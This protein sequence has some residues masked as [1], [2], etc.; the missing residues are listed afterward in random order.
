MAFLQESIFPSGI[1]QDSELRSVPQGDFL[2][3]LNIRINSTAGNQEGI[4]SNIKGNVLVAFTLP[5]GNNTRIGTLSDKQTGDVY[6]FIYNSNGNHGIFRFRQPNLIETVFISPLLNF[7]PDY[8]INHAN[9]V[10]E[11]LLYWTDGFNPPRK[12]NVEKALEGKQR[13]YNIYLGDNSGT[14]E[15]YE[16]KIKDPNGNVI[17]SWTILVPVPAVGT[18]DAFYAA[19]YIV[20]N[21]PAGVPATLIQESAHIFLTMSNIGEYT[22]EA[23]CIIPALSDQVIA[24]ADNFYPKP[25]VED[26]IDRLKYPFHCEPVVTY[27]ADQSIKVNL[28]KEKVFQFRMGYVYDDDEYSSLSPISSIPDYGTPCAQSISQ[29]ALNYIEIDFTEARLNNVSSRAIIKYV[30]IYFREHNDGKWKLVQTITPEEFGIGTQLF[31]FYNDGLY[32]VISDE[33]ADTLFSTLPIVAGATE[34]IGK[35]LTDSNIVEGYDPVNVDA[36]LEVKYNA[37]AFTGVTISGGVFIVSLGDLLSGTGKQPM[38]YLSGVPAEANAVFGG[39][40]QTFAQPNEPIIN[41]STNHSQR[42]PIYGFPFYLAGTDLFGVTKQDIIP[43]LSAFQNTT[44]GLINPIGLTQR[45]TAWQ[46]MR[47]VGYRQSWQITNVPPGRYLLRVGSHLTTAAELVDGTRKYQR[48]ST[49]IR[50]AAQSQTTFIDGVVGTGLNEAILEVLANGTVNIYSPGSFLLI[51]TSTN[52]VLPDTHIADISHQEFATNVSPNFVPG[53]LGMMGYLTDGEGTITPTSFSEGLNLE[54]VTRTKVNIEFIIRQIDLSESTHNTSV[55]TDHNGFFWWAAGVRTDLHP[56]LKQVTLQ[57]YVNAAT[58]VVSTV[59]LHDINNFV[60]T[61][62]QVTFLSS[63]LSIATVKL[64]LSYY[65]SAAFTANGRTFIEGVITDIGGNPLSGVNVAIVWHGSIRTDLNGRYQISF[66]HAYVNVHTAYIVPSS[67]GLCAF[68]IISPIIGYIITVPFFIGSANYNDT[69]LFT[70]NDFIAGLLFAIRTNALKRGGDYEIGY[71]YYDRGNRSNTVSLNEKLKLHIYFYTEPDASNNVFPAGQ[72]DVT[73]KTRHLPPVFFIDA[74]GVKHYPTHYQLLRTK[75][76]Q[77][78]WYLQWLANEVRYTDKPVPAPASN[79]MTYASGTY[80]SIKLTNFQ[81]YYD[82]NAASQIAYNYTKGDRIR[83]IADS[84]DVMHTQYFDFEILNWDSVAQEI[85]IL[86]DFSLP[87]QFAGCFFEI[88]SPRPDI[89]NKLYFECSECYEVKLDGN[90]NPYHEAPTQNQN[91]ADPYNTPAILTLKTGDAWYRNRSIPYTTSAPQQR[92]EFVDD[93]SI[94]DFYKSDDSSIGRINILELN[95]GQIRRGKTLRW[96]GD[97]IANLKINNLSWNLSGDTQ[98]ILK[99]EGTVN[100]LQVAGRILLAMQGGQVTSVYIYESQFLDATG[101]VNVIKADA[102]IGSMNPLQLLSGTNHPESVQE[103]QGRVYYYDAAKGQVVR[104]SND[105]QT[106][107]S[108][109]GM[110]SYFKNK[111]KT[112]TGRAYG[113]IVPKNLEYGITFYDTL[114]SKSKD[115]VVF[116]D[117]ERSRRWTSRYSFVPEGYAFSDMELI[118]FRDGALWVGER[119]NLRNNFF[120]VQYS[121]RLTLV[122]NENNSKTRTFIALVVDGSDVWHA[123]NDNDIT[124]P[125]SVKYPQGMKS[126]LLKNLFRRNATDWY[127]PFKKDL[128]SPNKTPQE[129]I[130]NG[131]DLMGHVIKISLQNDSTEEVTLKSVGVRYL[132]DEFTKK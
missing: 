77:L 59:P 119:N 9:I 12:I 95:Y 4:V 118:M 79:T 107:I 48:T 83:F 109:Y 57:Q 66:Y 75:N 112:F 35:K 82:I 41:P 98:D 65:N 94:S 129:A 90:G 34:F 30:T 103:Y 72:P 73:V 132:V 56:G 46:Y 51:Y 29:N 130:S 40:T 123:P 28:V 84:N 31:R 125:P 42:A 121:S 18:A 10:D 68:Q 92:T 71:V 33:L 111:A 38:W 23:A 58:T 80:L 2:D 108:D 62:Y 67:T 69:T 63:M 117:Q 7:S 44:T 50:T 49:T 61:F 91:P 15:T 89:E 131:R 102:F 127:T 14:G 87:E 86:K 64:G 55:I 6:Y 36:E 85:F 54:R 88:Y 17:F 114:P 27:K 74:L 106:V 43:A 47:N 105:G 113:F 53:G 39:W 96:S 115:T 13:T 99:G 116:C 1:N 78:N 97:Y 100:K 76:L 24:L 20:S 26:F 128:N 5:A 16:F 19:H 101:N 22:F 124:I 110:I 60:N 8:L 11:K 21:L 3:S 126:R 122:S 45:T 37:K 93:G 25:Y 104:Y 81:T 52:G 32:P 120:N 70:G